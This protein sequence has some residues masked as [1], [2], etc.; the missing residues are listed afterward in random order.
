MT[1]AVASFA[2]GT[3][4]TVAG[5]AAESQAADAQNK[6]AEQN[7]LNALA[8]FEDTQRSMNER[9]SQERESAALEKFDVALES[10]A[11]RA[12]NDVAAGEAGIS[13]V[14]VDALAKDFASREARFNDRVDRQTEWTTAQ[15][16]A[17]KREQSAQTLDRI[18]REPRAQKPS[19]IGAGLKIAASGLN[20]YSQSKK[21]NP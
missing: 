18:N 10:R 20:A 5:F 3:A 11:A 2:V 21:L 6:V 13:G 8:A 12:T 14:T 1:L 16:S 17:Q 7:R 9:I 19:F 15:L 4:S